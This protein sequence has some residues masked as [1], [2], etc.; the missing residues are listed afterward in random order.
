MDIDK[1]KTDLTAKSDE[2]M[3][4]E[5][6]APE[7][8]YC[9]PMTG[10]CTIMGPADGSTPHGM[11]CDPDTGICTYLEALPDEEPAE[12]RLGTSTKPYK[13][14]YVTDPICS[15]CWQVE[16]ELRKLM[17]HYDHIMDMQIVMGGLLPSWDDFSDEENTIHIPSDVSEHWRAAAK[18]HGMPIDGSLWIHDPIESSFPPSIAFKLVERISG[19]SARR[20]L[21]SIREA[22]MVFNEN[23]AKDEVL[24]HLLDRN[25]RNGKKVVEDT[26]TPEAR[27]LLNE[28]LTLSYQIGAFSFPTVI[29]LDQYGNGV[30]ILGKQSFDTYEEALTSLAGETPDAQPLPELKEMFDLSRNIFFKEIETMYELQPE[31]VAPFVRHNLPEGSYEERE[32][33]G[34]HYIIKK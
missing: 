23:V 2:I 5:Q 10:V 16:P 1:K 19:T 15:Y 17:A 13:L 24:I 7:V 8:P 3:V 6:T 9:D 31:E 12:I 32:I 18:E 4:N 28:D 29:L 26:R 33:L 14:I 21:R 34:S 27:E 30:R 22:A 25:D 20:F 11:Y